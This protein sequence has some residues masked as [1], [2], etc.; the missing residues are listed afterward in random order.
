MNSILLR[1]ASVSASQPESL[2]LLLC[3]AT[4]Y[5]WLNEPTRESAKGAVTVSHDQIGATAGV[6][7]EALS[8]HGPLTFAA[9]MERVDAPQSLF[10]MAIGW[11]SRE[12]KLRFESSGGDYLVRLA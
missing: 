12:E 7:W 6:L 11:L 9:L 3:R 8:K 1:L 2:D 5:T 10:F 4:A